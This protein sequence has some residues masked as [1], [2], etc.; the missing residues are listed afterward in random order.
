[1]SEESAFVRALLADS[2]DVNKYLMD[3]LHP[4]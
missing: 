1:M 4:V 3:G 2:R